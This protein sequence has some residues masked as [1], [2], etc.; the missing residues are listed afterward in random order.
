M[1]NHF[2]ISQTI[3]Q[4]NAQT[5]QLSTSTSSGST[6]PGAFVCPPPSAFLATP[7]FTEPVFLLTGYTKKGSQN[8]DS[9][10]QDIL[11]AETSETT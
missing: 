11:E 4:Q 5:N 9:N 6:E 1:L 7:D 3:M 10:T 2:K 8:H